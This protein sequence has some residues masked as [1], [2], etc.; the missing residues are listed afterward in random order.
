MPMTTD[1]SEHS[2]EKPARYRLFVIADPEAGTRIG[3]YL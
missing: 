3:S 1:T 2:L